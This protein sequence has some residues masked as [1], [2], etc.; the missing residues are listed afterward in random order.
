MVVKIVV[1]VVVMLVLDWHLAITS[2]R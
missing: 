1:T 2:S